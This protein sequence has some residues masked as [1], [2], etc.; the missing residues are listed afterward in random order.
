[1]S[2]GRGY[3][4]NRDRSNRTVGDRALAPRMFPPPFPTLSLGGVEVS[5]VQGRVGRLQRG[6]FLQGLLEDSR[7]RPCL[8]TV[9]FRHLHVGR[10]YWDRV[11]ACVSGI[12]GQ[13]RRRLPTCCGFRPSRCASLPVC[14]ACRR[15]GTTCRRWST[16]CASRRPKPRRS[17]APAPRRTPRAT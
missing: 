2:P 9:A 7:Q 17:C 11:C 3:V 8:G 4:R 12:P 13:R 10:M 15:G 5:S 1:M 16:A 14:A 6:E